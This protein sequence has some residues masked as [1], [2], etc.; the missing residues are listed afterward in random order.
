[1]GVR[2]RGGLDGVGTW[3]N[4]PEGAKVCLRLVAHTVHD[5]RAR[6]HTLTCPTNPNPNANPNHAAAKS[7]F[8][9]VAACRVGTPRG[10]GS[11]RPSS[12][13]RRYRPYAGLELTAGRSFELGEQTDFILGASLDGAPPPVAADVAKEWAWAGCAPGLVPP[14]AAHPSACL[15]ACLAA[16]SARRPRSPRPWHTPL[17]ERAQPRLS[18]P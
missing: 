4:G 9:N 13:S 10:R 16:S 5:A 14:A 12:P 1:M 18:R 8:R 17:P 3:A 6:W 2:S 15:A 7:P 11:S